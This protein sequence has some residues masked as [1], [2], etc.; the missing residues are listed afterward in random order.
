MVTKKKVKKSSL[1]LDKFRRAVNSL[2]ITRR[3]LKKG[4]KEGKVKITRKNRLKKSFKKWKKVKE[5]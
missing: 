1:R 4:K 5:L 3:L 2:I